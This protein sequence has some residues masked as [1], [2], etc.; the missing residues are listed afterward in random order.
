M[1]NNV[2]LFLSSLFLITLF[3][4]CKKSDAIS[5]N[6]SFTIIPQSSVPQTIVSSFSSSFNG[7]TEVEW[8]RS[9]SNHVGVEFNHSNQ[10][11]GVEFEDNGSHKSHSISCSTAPVPLVVLNAFRAQYPTEIVYQWKLTNDGTWKAHFN[12]ATI[13]WEATFSATGILLKAE[14]SK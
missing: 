14:Q 4:S 10:R 8:H 1:K 3:F 2:K 5:S 6:D 13:K 7:A 9:S 12:R 11:H